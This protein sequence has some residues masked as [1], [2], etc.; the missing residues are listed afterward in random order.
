MRKKKHPTELKL[1]LIR[2]KQVQ[3]FL[4]ISASLAV[5]M[6]GC[7]N[8]SDQV[9]RRST[10]NADSNVAVSSSQEEGDAVFYETAE[11]CR[12]DIKQQ[13]EEYQVLLK[14]YE[15]G[16][17]STKPTIPPMKAE[18]CEAQIQAAKEAHETNSPVY[19]SRLDCENAGYR[20]EATPVGYY[21]SGYRPVFGGTYFYYGSPDY[22]Y[23]Y[24][25]ST[26][27][28]V[29]RPRTV[30]YS[31]DNNRVVTASGT[32]F[33]RSSPGRVKI[34]RQTTPNTSNLRS[35]PRP[36]GQAASG[37][38]KGRGSNGFGSTFKSTGKGGK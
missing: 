30:Y 13:N 32:S 28:Q 23:V 2:R 34:P 25:G 33:S 24:R 16:T 35:T 26:R 36:K 22:V 11:Q 7:S 15:A 8:N 17:L 37:A 31:R 12:A 18:N 21:T 6:S 20:C 10:N 27:Y 4:A 5:M 3:Q 9:T 38:V 14:A 19:D 1:R 29:Y